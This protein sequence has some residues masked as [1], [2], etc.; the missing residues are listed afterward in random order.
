FMKAQ[1]VKIAVI[2]PSGAKGGFVTKLIPIDA[3][4]DEIIQEGISCYKD[5]I[6]GLLDIT[7]NYQ[8]GN[9][10]PP[11]NVVRHDEDDPYLVVAADKGTATFSDIANSISAEYEFW[12][13]DAF[14]SGGSS[15]YD[16]KKMA[17]T[18][19]G[20]WESVKRHFRCCDMDIQNEDFTV[21]GIGDMSGDVF[22]NGMLLSRHIKLLAAFDH[23]HIFIDPSPDPETS[24]KERE[25]LFHLPRSSWDDYNKQLIS[26]GGGVFPRNVKA[27]KLSAE[28]KALLDIQKDIIIPNE[29]ICHILKAKVDLLW[30]GG[31]GTFVKSSKETNLD[32]G[33]RTTDGTRVNGNEL[34]CRVVGEGGNLGFTQLGRIEYDLNGGMIFTDFIDNSAGVDCSD[35]EVNVKILLNEVMTSGDMTLKQ[36][37]KLLLQMTEEVARLVL[38]NNYHQTQ[39]IELSAHLALRNVDLHIQYMRELTE[40]GYIDPKLEFLPD[41][42]ELHERKALGRGL[43]RPELAIIFAYTKNILKKNILDSDIPEGPHLSK[44]IEYAFPE[45]IRAKFP[46]QMN[47]HRL[48][49]EIIATII[50]STLVNETGTTF[51]YQLTNQTG[52]PTAAIIRAYGIARAIFSIP[53]L[54][55]EIEGLDNK[56]SSSIQLEMLGVLARLARRSTRWFLRNRRARFNFEDI[57]N[58]FAKD[59]VSLC[60]HLPEL[61]P[62][63]SKEIYSLNYTRLV[64]LGVSESVASFVAGERAM[65]SALDIIDAAKQH[66]CDVME[67]ADV[68][69]TLGERMDLYWFREQLDN[70]IV[71]NQWENFAREA[72]RDD[73]D[74][75][76]RRLAISVLRH[77]QESLDITGK[78]DEWLKARDFLVKHWQ[79][80]LHSIKS[81]VGCFSIFSV[82]VR[83]LSDLAQIES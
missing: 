5:F 3:S 33:D 76:Q 65:I 4:R 24:Y 68:Y 78:I 32:V 51:I 8:S 37:D 36:R 20:A 15:G 29:L 10:I 46:K 79:K 62:G 11:A 59:I 41:E 71:D 81:N 55:K 60:K 66:Q 64:E 28:V 52:A 61:L 9:L 53:Q 1:N 21:V 17:I 39:S 23:R 56:I 34:R 31:I 80:V 19:R 38:D 58:Y 27:I 18:A 44:A 42:H 63:S 14:A 40:S 47:A 26:K 49:R 43:T 35:H 2:V 77:E 7:D 30:N 54:R 22:G 12:L 82:A 45:P 57:Q 48:K 67:L 72:C 6:R 25:R 16:H 83:E 75:L 70:Y 73:L 69:F 50:S 74:L 13:G